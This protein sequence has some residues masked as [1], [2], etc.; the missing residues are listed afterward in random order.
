MFWKK[1][2]ANTQNQEEPSKSKASTPRKFE[3]RS[4]K[5]AGLFGQ[6]KRQQKNLDALCCEINDIIVKLEDLGH[7]D[8]RVSDLKPQEMD[9]LNTHQVPASTPRKFE[10][11]STKL[12]GLFRRNKRQQKNLDALCCEIND[13]I[14]KLEDLGHE[15][16]S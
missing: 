5:L 16:Q 14:V 12:G 6:N 3:W 7:D 9:A 1:R 8:Q 4:T 2:S 13:I 11:R 15:D 10:W